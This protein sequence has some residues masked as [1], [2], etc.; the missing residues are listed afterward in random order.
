M[1]FGA[2]I[3]LVQAGRQ[4][5]IH[6]QQ[7][8]GQFHVAGCG[9]EECP[10]CGRPL[11]GCDCAC[12]A[13]HDGEKIIRGIYRQFSDLEGA[14]AAIGRDTSDVSAASYLNHAA[15]QFIFD[16]VPEAA[17][18]EITRVFHLRFPGL[19]PV[20]QDEQG[21]AYYTAEQLSA[22]LDIPLSEVNE[23]IDAMV[24]A[25]QG[26]VIRDGGTLRKVH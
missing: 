1:P 25:G 26:I 18:E 13:P 6:C 23:R 5:C 20:L 24:S 7:P 12:L 22:A 10:K 8:L 4:R 3:T 15:M 11:I 2:E 17:R 16:H 19:V 9:A 21:R 14:L